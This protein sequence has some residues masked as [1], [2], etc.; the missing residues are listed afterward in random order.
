VPAPRSAVL[1]VV[2]PVRHD[3]AP[4]QCS[5]KA[6]THGR[7]NGKAAITMGNPRIC[8]VEMT[9]GENA[10]NGAVG[11]LESVEAVDGAALKLAGAATNAIPV[12]AP[13][14]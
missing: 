13:R 9:L 10:A 2:L 5:R 12:G 1:A 11:A 14:K 8:E 4:E 3:G 6:D 7:A